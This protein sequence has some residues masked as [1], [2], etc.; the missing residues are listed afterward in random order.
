MEYVHTANEVDIWHKRVIRRHIRE[1]YPE[2]QR[3]PLETSKRA[4]RPNNKPQVKAKIYA[5]D[6]QPID[7]KADVVIAYAEFSYNNSHYS[8]IGMTLNHNIRSAFSPTVTL[9]VLLNSGVEAALMCL[10][11]LRLPSC[12]RTPH[13]THDDKRRSKPLKYLVPRGTQIPYS[14]IT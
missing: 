13:L 3:A 2:T 5:L 12:V 8:L 6:R 14:A 1:Q 10:D 9:H 4:G 11:S 7:S